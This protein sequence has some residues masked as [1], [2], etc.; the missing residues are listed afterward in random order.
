MIEGIAPE[1]AY[2]SR[3]IHS[4]LEHTNTP[5]LMC[6]QQSMTADLPL[7]FMCFVLGILWSLPKALLC[8]LR[9]FCR[10]C[11]FKLQKKSKKTQRL[12]LPLKKKN[13]SQ[14]AQLI[15]ARGIKTESDKRK[16]SKAT[17]GQ[18]EN[19]SQHQPPNYLSQS[20]SP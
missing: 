17:K 13:S 11:H 7:F 10:F 6:Q 9:R 19:E 12:Y 15:D 4:S 20:H 2:C 1:Q 14:V 5:R 16:K 8:F 3:Q 18:K